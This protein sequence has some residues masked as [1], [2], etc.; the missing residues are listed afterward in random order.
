MFLGMIVI[1]WTG[2]LLQLNRHMIIILLVRL[3]VVLIIDFFL[4]AFNFI[5]VFQCKPLSLDE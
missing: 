3:I 5:W 1:I 2:R 4:Y